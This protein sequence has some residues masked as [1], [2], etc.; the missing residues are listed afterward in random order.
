MATIDP[1]HLHD[2]RETTH[3]IARYEASA[4]VSDM[5]WRY[6]IPTWSVPAG[7]VSEQKVL[8]HPVCLVVVTPA[9]ARFYGVARGLSRTVLD[10]DGW[11]FGVM[12][13]P[14][15][16]HLL[17]GASVD[18]VTDRHVPLT[19]VAA[20]GDAYVATVRELMSAAPADPA[21]HRSAID[22]LEGRVAVHPVDDEGLLVNRIVDT[23]TS[24]DAI[25]RVDDLCDAVGLTERTL[26]RLCR[27]RLGLTPSWLIR[28][29]RLHR[30]ADE[31][32]SA[33]ADLAGL[34]ADLGYADQA[35]FSRDFRLATGFRPREFATRAAGG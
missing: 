15:A 27:R 7:E 26:H 35:H 14:A 13:R 29:H 8:Q 21:V 28:R 20:F 12:L 22:V 11:A 1:A 34:A 16:G 5:V 23:V 10:G 33:P 30:A 9:Y 2:P 3:T 18:T 25:L 4:A 6:W 19:D 24:G 32:S 31:L 17:L